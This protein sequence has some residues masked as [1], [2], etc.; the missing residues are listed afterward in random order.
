[1]TVSATSSKALAAPARPAPEERAA[2]DVAT[3]RARAEAATAQLVAA[4]TEWRRGKNEL[5]AA[6][7]TLTKV[8]NEVKEAR[9]A[10]DTAQV[11]LGRYASAAYRQHAVPAELTVLMALP[12][13]VSDAL[14]ALQLLQLTGGT[15]GD[16][17]KIAEDLAVRAAQVEDEAE[18]L[19]AQAE[20]AANRLT[21][22]LAE[23]QASTTKT[24]RALTSALAELE[25]IEAEKR[26]A[27]ARKAAAKRAATARASR[28]RAGASK[29]TSGVTSC[30]AGAGSTAGYAN[31][32]IPSSALCPIGGG[33]SLRADA[34]GAFAKLNTAYSKRFGTSIC[35]RDAYR[36]L[37][38]QRR[39]FA[40]TPWLAAV[41]GTSNHG[42]GKA[43]DL[44][45]GINT[46]GTVTYN[47]M[48][49]N[50]TRFGWFHP[51]WAEPGGSMPEPWHWEYT[52]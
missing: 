38:E 31:G 44:C 19:A 30:A 22:E 32:L 50:S 5:D 39:V 35:V 21:K 4:T 18:R 13:D 15:K 43:L 8:R 7:A 9:R 46:F 47:W 49:A 23:I 1:M 37:E 11:D 14:H 17:V 25:R 41:P 10:S 29:V 26:A 12:A 42:W 40:A 16:V 34:A 28:A 51:A 33:F 20:V 52:G 27:A 24:T 6:R 45:G 2:I 3:L 48:K 36:S